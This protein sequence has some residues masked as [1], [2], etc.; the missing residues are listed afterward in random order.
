MFCFF[1][2][3]PVYTYIRVILKNSK[4]IEFFENN[5]R[6]VSYFLT[7]SSSSSSNTKRLVVASALARTYMHI[8]M[9]EARRRDARLHSC[10]HR[11]NTCKNQ[12]SILYRMI[13]SQIFCYGNESVLLSSN[14]LTGCYV[15]KLSFIFY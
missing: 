4:F 2:Q 13:R 6:S 12:I 14:L 10:Q 5:D 15:I 3:H 8:C 7:S 1:L 9:L 11:V